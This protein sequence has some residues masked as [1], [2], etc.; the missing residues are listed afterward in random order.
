MQP[1]GP[2]VPANLLR[3]ARSCRGCGNSLRSPD[4]QQDY[5]LTCDLGVDREL[6]S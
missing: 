2:R 1:S 4:A 3:I 6:W 5:A